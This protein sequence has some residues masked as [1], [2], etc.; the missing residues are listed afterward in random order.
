MNLSITRLLSASFFTFFIKALG[1]GLSFIVSILITR[2]LGVNGAGVYFLCF[3]IFILF[4]T[5]V[6]LGL[7]IVIIKRASIH[8]IDNDFGSIVTLYK[9]IILVVVP[10]SLL[11]TSFLY[12]TSSYVGEI[13]FKSEDISS[14]LKFMGWGVLFFAL[15]NI[16]SSF[17]LATAQIK[18]S[19]LFIAIIIPLLFIAFLY[20]MPTLM[21]LT[22]PLVFGMYC[23]SSF[24]VFV[25]SFLFLKRSLHFPLSTKNG[26]S[27]KDLLKSAFPI[28]VTVIIDL[29][30]LI[31]PQLLLGALFSEESVAI[32]SV[33]LR[34]STLI[35][36]IFVSAS[37]V[38]APQIASLYD[39]GDLTK[40]NILVVKLTRILF[41]VAFF[42]SII[43]FIFP[44]IFLGFF[45]KEYEAGAQ[46]LRCFALLQL[47][48]V[49]YGMSKTL[50]QMTKFEK[51]CRNVTFYYFVLNTTICLV[52]IPH[53]TY[54]GAALSVL[55]STSLIAFY[56]T[57]LVKK[58]LGISIFSSKKEANTCA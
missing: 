26:F 39:K 41:I 50:L 24:L 7:D 21:E 12:L 6:R 52:L 37:R 36:F 15:C 43:V 35:G 56:T 33:C 5:V 14:V 54:F 46:T 3:S 40:L 57:Y 58:H 23:F 32:F 31:T 16:N 4:G 48:L 25:I 20:S 45:G 51:E 47:V 53:F 42:V 49:F 38:A 29:L 27:T 9:K 2:Y 22:P 10:L 34:I 8:Y 18:Q 17:F 55:I 1:A 28:Y 19:S 11:L 44:N 13:I 30:V